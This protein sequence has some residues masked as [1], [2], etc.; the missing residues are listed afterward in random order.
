MWSKSVK[1]NNINSCGDEDLCSL[2]D[3][4]SAIIDNTVSCVC[5]LNEVDDRARAVFACCPG[6][7]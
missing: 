6:K 7:K 4:T 5:S 1:K 3:H 2:G